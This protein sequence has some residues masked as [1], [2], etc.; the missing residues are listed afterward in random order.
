LAWF[1]IVDAAAL[2]VFGSFAL[3]KF[4]QSRYILD[5]RTRSAYLVVFTG[6]AI[7]LNVVMVMNN[8]INLLSGWSSNQ[9]L[10]LAVLFFTLP[11]TRVGFIC[12]VIRL[13][14]V[15]HPKAK[16]DMPWL[17]PEKNHIAMLLETYS[18]FPVPC[19][20]VATREVYHCLSDIL[21]TTDLTIA[22]LL[23]ALYPLIRNVDD[24]FSISKELAVVM[25]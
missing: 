18:L 13:A 24:L 16:H 22:A 23:A 12:R 21:R 1:R 25:A 3:V 15:F 7:L 8:S 11:I 19:P 14:V 2:V 4:Y 9:Y 20:H 6:A 17:I 10:V 5:I